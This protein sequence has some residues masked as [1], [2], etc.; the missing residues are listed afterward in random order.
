MRARSL[1]QDGFDDA[2]AAGVVE[3]AGFYADDDRQ[4]SVG[5]GEIVGHGLHLRK[6]FPMAVVDSDRL[7]GDGVVDLLHG[8]TIPWTGGHSVSKGQ[9]VNN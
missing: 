9:D 7:A 6:V 1:R 2:F 8:G 4:F 3:G 5:S